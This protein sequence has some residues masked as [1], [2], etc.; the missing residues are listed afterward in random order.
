[1]GEAPR[2]LLTGLSAGHAPPPLARGKSAL[3]RALRGLPK[4]LL[5]VRR[6]G[7]RAL[8]VVRRPGGAG[9]RPWGRGG[10]G[11]GALEAGAGVLGA[12]RD[13]CR[14]QDLWGGLHRP[15]AKQVGGR[16]SWGQ[17]VWIGVFSGFWGGGSVVQGRL[18]LGVAWELNVA[19]REIT[20][21]RPG[22]RP[23]PVPGPQA[24]ARALSPRPTRSAPRLSPPSALSGACAPWSCRRRACACCP[25]TS[26]R[27]TA[28]GFPRARPLSPVS[29]AA[30][31]GRLGW[32]PALD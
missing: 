23:S 13:G 25:A 11:A 1:M 32:G 30:G 31:S 29:R 15:V 28:F 9:R 14:G 16:G 4:D 21:G 20:E 27:C 26:A 8:R 10:R 5:L 3:G 19:P 22:P 24:R 17:L 2:S 12:G 18:R 7:R 6:A